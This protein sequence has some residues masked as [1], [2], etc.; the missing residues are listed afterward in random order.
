MRGILKGWVMISLSFSR[1]WTASGEQMVIGGWIVEVGG[2]VMAVGVIVRVGGNSV[3]VGERLGVGETGGGAVGSG[4]GF[5]AHE[6]L[7]TRLKPNK[8]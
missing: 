6:V 3:A 5:F 8:T 1:G 7:K 4:A 2:K